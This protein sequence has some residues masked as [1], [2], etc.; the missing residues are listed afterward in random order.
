MRTRLVPWVALL[1][2]A[3]LPA[4]ARPAEGTAAKPAFII[5]LAP[6]DTL[7]EDGRY[8]SELA[9]KEDDAKNVEGILKGIIGEK[10]LEGID[11]K[12]PLGAY[13]TIGP[14][15]LDST[16]VVLV[17]VADEQAFLGLVEKLSGN[18]PDKGGDGVY[19]ANVERI[20]YP[21]YFRFAN[22]YCYITVGTGEHKKAID[23]DA[24]L[25]PAVVLPGGKVGTLSAMV[26]IDKIPAN[27]KQMALGQIDLQLAKAK[28]KQR[29]DETPAQ[30]KLKEAVLD[31]V[32]ARIKSLLRDGGPVDVRV[33]LDRSAGDLSLSVSLAG[34]PDSPLAATIADLG[35][36]RGLA[37]SL[38]GSDS[39]MSG[40]LD[41]ALPD[42]LR[43]AVGPVIDE[44]EQKIVG[45][46]ENKVQRDILEAVL[47]AVKPT[48]KAGELDAGFDLRG[49]NADG[50]YT[51]VAGIKVKDGEQIDKALHK[52]VTDLPPEARDLIKL[53]FDKVDKVTI[54]RVTAHGKVNKDI[55]LGD[56]PVF[57]AVREDALL[58]AAGDKGLEALK[59]VVG[60]T[61]KASPVAQLKLSV[62]RLAP[63]MEKENK[64]AVEAAKKVFAKDKDA[65]K[66]RITVEGGSALQLRL[67]LKTQLV[68]FFSMIDTNK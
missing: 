48:L 37:A 16:A 51:A 33:N 32:S 5:R 21:V 8:L 65:D 1:G 59:E 44:G 31:E 41:L 29:P 30:A 18:K 58:L 46:Q 12:K 34:K 57:V 50:I 66:V 39:A 6:L 22:K 9:G 3:L 15:G 14:M 20:P 54:H 52:I 10:G 53:D 13:G 36:L 60:A 19:T 68:K 47:N 2:L 25:D 56:N 38:A 26:N 35:K 64:G 28:E 42:K 49:P 27:L 11:T 4:A 43:S 62:A 17:P 67:V 61:A 24:L 63:L 40:L 7:A 45:K 23:K 55:P